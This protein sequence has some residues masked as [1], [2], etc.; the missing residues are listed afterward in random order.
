MERLIE[1]YEKALTEE[2]K[3]HNEMDKGQ[4]ALT[5]HEAEEWCRIIVDDPEL[6]RWKAQHAIALALQA[7]PLYRQITTK[8]IRAK[9]R[10]REAEIHLAVAH[11]RIELTKARLYGGHHDLLDMPEV[12]MGT[13]LPLD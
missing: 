4:F 8:F 13:D 12:E 7:N 3:Q 10:H 9:L 2:T 6:P 5:L 11:E 1:D